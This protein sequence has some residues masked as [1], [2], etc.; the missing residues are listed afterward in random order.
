VRCAPVAAASG[1]G[2]VRGEV[3]LRDTT[4][5]Y[6][7]GI[8]ID[9]GICRMLLLGDEELDVERSEESRGG[10]LIILLRPVVVC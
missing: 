4:C 5:V 10:G 9:D 6:W 3:V 8:I 1:P 7:V 2:F